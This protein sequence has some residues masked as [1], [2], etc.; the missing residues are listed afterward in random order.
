MVGEAN[1]ISGFLP[2]TSAPMVTHLQ[3]A[4]DTIIFCA[5]EEE[6]VK[7]VLTIL[8]CFKDV[9]KLKVNVGKNELIEVAVEE[10]FLQYFAGILGCKVGSL[11]TSYLSLPLTTSSVS[12]SPWN[13]VVERVELKLASWKAK[14][15]LLVV[16]LP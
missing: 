11:P 14:A 6:Q 12:K 9:S 4:N 16:E 1:L 13:K 15:Y 3:F 2:A 10:S 8:R 5:A 7:N